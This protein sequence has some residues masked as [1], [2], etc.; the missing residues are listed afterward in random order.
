MNS[1]QTISL[2]VCVCGVAL[3]TPFNWFDDTQDD[4]DIDVD[5]PIFKGDETATTTTGQEDASAMKAVDVLADYLYSKVS[6]DVDE[7]RALK[8]KNK[9]LAKLMARL[10]FVVNHPNKARLQG[11]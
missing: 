11:K 8:K 6:G 2:L 4:I 3:G 5:M 7:K 10:Q 9:F 1:L